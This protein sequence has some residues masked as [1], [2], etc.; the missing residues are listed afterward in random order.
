MRSW[1]LQQ[2]RCLVQQVLL[3]PRLYRAFASPIPR[4]LSCTV[5]LFEQLFLYLKFYF[6]LE[7]EM[8]DL[9]N[10]NRSPDSGTYPIDQTRCQALSTIASIEEKDLIQVTVH[11]VAGISHTTDA[12]FFSSN[13]T[14][15]AT[16]TCHGTTLDYSCDL[17]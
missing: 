13:S 6:I 7:G 3:R 5:S 9:L 10:N 17:L 14:G 1:S 12:V 16:F 15:T 2:Q 8:K 4:D 11:A